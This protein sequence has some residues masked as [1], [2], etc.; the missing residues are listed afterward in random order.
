MSEKRVGK[1]VKKGS[2]KNV[3]KKG[4]EKNAKNKLFCF[5]TNIKMLHKFLHTFFKGFSNM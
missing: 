1:N 3:K 2:G 4:S 5:K